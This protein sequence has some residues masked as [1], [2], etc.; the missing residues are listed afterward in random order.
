MKTL[1]KSALLLVLSLVVLSC[2]TEKKIEL[3]NGQ[4]LDNWN[5]IVDSEDGE[6][7]DLFYVEDGLMNTIGD[8]FGYIRTKESY[9]NYKLHLEWRWTEEPSNS[10][11]LLNVQG[12]EL[13]FP[14]CVEAQLMHG[15]AGDFVLMGKGAAI[16]VKDSTYLVTSEERRYLAIQKFEESSENPA[17]EW[18][19]YDITSKDG[20]LELYVNSV[21]QNKGTGMTLT[22]GNIALQSEGGPMQFRNIYLQPL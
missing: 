4:D 18:N 16:T 21:L 20:I 12:P 13:I 19:S 5:I 9:S 15:K 22:E 2:S 1:L 3:F 11:V 14:H 6:P 10:G 7:K 8:P 17:G